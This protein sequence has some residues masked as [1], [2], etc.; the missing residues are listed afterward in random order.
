MKEQNCSLR[1]GQNLATHETKSCRGI[2]RE[3]RYVATEFTDACRV[4]QRSRKYTE[5][6]LGILVKMCINCVNKPVYNVEHKSKT[7]EYKK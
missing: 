6:P 4:R 2:F 3:L 1:H 7:Y 5:K